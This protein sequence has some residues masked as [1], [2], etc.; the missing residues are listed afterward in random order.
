MRSEYGDWERS[1]SGALYVPS[2]RAYR[3]S[4][5][6]IPIYDLPR[7][8]LFPQ[9]LGTF[10]QQT[11]AA[12][13]A[14]GS[15]NPTLGANSTAGNLVTVA[16]ALDSG[17]ATCTVSGMG[18]LG[19]WSVIKDS[20]S[21]GGSS[22][23]YLFAA[24]V[25]TGNTVLTITPSTGASTASIQEW[26]GY[27]VTTDGTNG[28]NAST[29]TSIHPGSITTANA[30]DLIISLCTTNNGGTFN[31]PGNPW[32]ALNSYNS[33]SPPTLHVDYQIVSSTG[34][35]DPLFSW[36]SSVSNAAAIAAFQAAIPATS[37]LWD[38]AQRMRPF[39]VR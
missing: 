10:V 35:F 24:I 38:P 6:E 39:L 5:R 1:R 27:T 26:T 19:N 9:L 7:A 14:S 16:V 4:S 3:P 28:A 11:T 12:R 8:P 36:A 33:G 23:V 20:G 2:R 31:E 37:L 17:S 32:T 18:V 34:S 15:P 30:N 21:K 25:V 29:G 13:V 22:R